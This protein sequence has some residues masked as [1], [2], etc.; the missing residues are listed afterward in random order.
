MIACVPIQL[1]VCTRQV[2]GG[3]RHVRF[4]A[5]RFPQVYLSGTEARDDWMNE[6]DS[7]W[8]QVYQCPNIDSTLSHPRRTYFTIT[9]VTKILILPVI[10]IPRILILPT[11]LLP[12]ILIHISHP[13]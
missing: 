11:I 5:Q 6:A 2:I 1:R 8:Q 7:V 10:L 12:H 3:G 13:L 4:E 9:F